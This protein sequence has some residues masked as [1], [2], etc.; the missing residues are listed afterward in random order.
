MAIENLQDM[1]RKQVRDA[2]VKH[3]NPQEE[4]SHDG[5]NDSGDDSVNESEEL[6]ESDRR[7]LDENWRS[8]LARIVGGGVSWLGAVGS[9]GIGAG[10]AIGTMSLTP[11]ALGFGGLYLAGVSYRAVHRW[12][13]RIEDREFQRA[14]TEL[15]KTVKER[16]KILSRLNEEPDPMTERTLWQLSTK[17][18]K[19]GKRLEEI[20]DKNDRIRDALS[21]RD[22]TELNDLINASRSGIL[23]FMKR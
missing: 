2:I 5:D 20:I 6:D 11:V 23:T 14:M 15:R 18:Q 10:M 16:D 4:P 8:S 17:Q 9:I 1:V 13:N 22:A 21:S 19:L 12:A 7:Q 3:V